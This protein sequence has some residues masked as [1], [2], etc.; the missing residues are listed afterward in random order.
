MTISS[1]TWTRHGESSS[2]RKLLILE[3]QGDLFKFLDMIRLNSKQA[4]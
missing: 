3:A 1:K 2:R 4:H